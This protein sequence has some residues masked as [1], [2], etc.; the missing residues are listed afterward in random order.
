MA[1]QYFQMPAPTWDFAVQIHMMVLQNP[2][3]SQEAIDGAKAEIRRLAQTVDK[4]NAEAGMEE[5]K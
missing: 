1:K 4:L 2:D 3:A 5:G